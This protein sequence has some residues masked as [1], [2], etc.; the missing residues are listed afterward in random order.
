MGSICTKHNDDDQPMMT[1]QS[2]SDL[3]NKYESLSQSYNELHDQYV[4]NQHLMACDQRFIAKC[5]Y[6]CSEVDAERMIDRICE[7]SPWIS[8]DVE[9]VRI[10][11]ILMYF[12]EQYIKN[13]QNDGNI[14]YI[15]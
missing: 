14:Q 3:S 13:Y 12:R 8:V 2:E 10:K 1:R 15:P 9:R 4:H 7:G 11:L 6:T 5:I